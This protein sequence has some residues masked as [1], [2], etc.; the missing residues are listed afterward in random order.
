MDKVCTQILSANLPNNPTH[1]GVAV[2]LVQGIQSPRQGWGEG[3]HTVNPEHEVKL[4][5]AGTADDP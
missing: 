3:L 1:E 2:P 4:A 5:W